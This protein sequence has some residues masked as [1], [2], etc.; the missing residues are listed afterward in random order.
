MAA[1]SIPRPRDAEPGAV[2]YKV[3]P[4]GCR[5]QCPEGLPRAKEQQAFGTGRR[6]TEV[7]QAGR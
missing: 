1:N 3:R 7:P 5:E 2:S 4:S 6:G